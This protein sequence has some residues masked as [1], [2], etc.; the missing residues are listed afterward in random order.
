MKL[1][2]LTAAALSMCLMSAAIAQVS[3]SPE[4]VLQKL[5]TTFVNTPFTEVRATPIEGIYEV[6]M[7]K[8]IAYTDAS[9][10]YFM[11]GNVMDMTTQRNLTADRRAEINKVDMSQL[12]LA[13][14][15][16]TVKGDGSRTLYVFSDPECAYCKRLEPTLAQLKNVTIYTFLYP[17]LGEKSRQSAKSVW[18]SA[19]RNKVWADYM[20]KGGSLPAA[21]CDNPVV[22]N[23][24]LGASFG[25]TGT[26]TMISAS[27]KLVPG[28]LP[29]EKIEEILA[30]AAPAKQ[31]ARTK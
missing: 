25:I 6:L 30:E 29:L 8:D 2:S 12:K 23:E 22:R 28:A 15:I 20:L 3:V 24:Q 16:K 11:F 17:V 7:G 1:K 4:S 27:G 9:A 26:P 14:A 5:K 18:C 13:D 19:D 10:R 31:A 21:E